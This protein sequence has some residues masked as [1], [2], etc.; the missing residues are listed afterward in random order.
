VRGLDERELRVFASLLTKRAFAKGATLAAEGEHGDRMWLIMK[1]SVDIRLRVDDARGS[2]RIA[3]LATGT[4][5]GEM[6][7]IENVPRSASI[8]AAED[9]V[10]W[11]LDRA[12][13][14][15]IVRD[16]PH[17]GTKLLT[18]LF[19]EMANRIRNT[20]EQLRETES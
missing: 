4:T 20:S 8:I 16:Y 7:L 5:V 12:T 13:Y 10:C 9:M 11:E 19:R 14:M 18:N 17:V 1:G 2:R 3:S 15:T 6:A